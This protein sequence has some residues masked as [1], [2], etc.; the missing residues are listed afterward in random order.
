[1]IFYSQDFQGLSAIERL[2][3]ASFLGIAFLIKE[4]IFAIADYIPHV[5]EKITGFIGE[6]SGKAVPAIRGF[7]DKAV[8][9]LGRVRPVLEDISTKGVAAFKFLAD[10][11]RTALQNIKRAGSKNFFYFGLLFFTILACCFFL[12]TQIFLSIISIGF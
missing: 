9:F 10:A 1:M 2:I 3:P 7:R 12:N 5:T 4:A 8:A 11:G 6:V